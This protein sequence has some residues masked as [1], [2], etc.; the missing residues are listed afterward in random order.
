MQLFRLLKVLLT[1]KLCKNRLQGI[2]AHAFKNALFMRFCSIY[3]KSNAKV[4]C[5]PFLTIF[6]ADLFVQVYLF[7]CQKSP[8]PLLLYLLILRYKL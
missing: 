8:F 4:R 6:K 7:Q 1:P 5:S 3:Q 2:Y